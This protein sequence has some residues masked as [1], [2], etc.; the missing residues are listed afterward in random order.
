MEAFYTDAGVLPRGAQ[1][2]LFSGL[3]A[4]IS[5]HMMNGTIAGQA[6]LFGFSVAAALALLVGYRTWI[7][8]LVSW[9]LVVSFHNRNPMVLQGGD[10]L[11][12]MML[13]W[14]LFLPLGARASLDR[15]LAAKNSAASDVTLAAKR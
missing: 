10:V 2:E 12:R 7:A 4:L 1:I 14:G 15:W 13:F 11:L 9:V 8:T 5:L 6:L 3:P